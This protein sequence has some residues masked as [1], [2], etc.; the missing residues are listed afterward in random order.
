MPVA[1]WLV[2][3]LLGLLV[4]HWSDFG[5]CAADELY[6]VGAGTAAVIG[7]AVFVEL[8]VV[9][10]SLIAE[11]GNTSANELLT[12]AVVRT[13]AG[14]FVISEGFALY[15]IGAK[16]SSTLLVFLVVVPMGLQLLLF[17]ECAYHRIGSSRIRSG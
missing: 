7:V 5:T 13:N 4:G 16:E 8:A 12:R 17:V 6:A 3:P 9:M 1:A 11:Q 14:L 15:A 2:A 10:G